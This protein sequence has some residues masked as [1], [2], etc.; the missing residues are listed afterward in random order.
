MSFPSSLSTIVFSATLVVAV[1]CSGKVQNLNKEWDI[2]SQVPP[3]RNWFGGGSSNL[4]VFPNRAD[5]HLILWSRAEKPSADSK[6]EEQ[7]KNE[8]VEGMNKGFGKGVKEGALGGL[9]AGC[10][11][12]PLLGC[13]LAPITMPLGAAFGGVAGGVSGGVNAAREKAAIEEDWT[14]HD[15]SSLKG[16]GKVFEERGSDRRLQEALSREVAALIE[17]RSAHDAKLVTYEDYLT[18]FVPNERLDGLIE[19]DVTHYR[20]IIDGH[21]DDS[22]ANPLIRLYLR[23]SVIFFSRTDAWEPYGPAYSWEYLGDPDKLSDLTAHNG[24][25]LDEEISSAMKLLAQAIVY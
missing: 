1:G 8:I 23:V 22:V 21:F 9:K 20:L 18:D 2:K 25:L 13:L 12:I 15:L 17:S 6:S 16:A 7:S 24:R 19:I 10:L 5:P 11:A 3:A 14:R 4:A